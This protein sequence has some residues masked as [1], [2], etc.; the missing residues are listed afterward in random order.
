VAPH[1]SYDPQWLSQADFRRL[2]R[3]GFL[4]TLAMT[5]MIYAGPWLGVPSL[6]LAGILGSMLS[7]AAPRIFSAIWWAG[8]AWHFINGSI[9]FPLVYLYLIARAG[10]GGTWLR[11]TGWGIVLWFLLQALVMPLVGGGFFS[12]Y[13][14]H[15]FAVDVSSL[16]AHVIYG[17]IVGEAARAIP[18]RIVVWREDRAA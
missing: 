8:L 12:I 1:S 6:D 14:A 15:P 18:E 13:L 11:G 17:A 2:L 5:A 10:H 4:A 7:G 9:L 16:L 3:G